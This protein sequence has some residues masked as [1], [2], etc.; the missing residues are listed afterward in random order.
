MSYDIHE[1]TEPVPGLEYAEYLAEKARI[2][3]EESGFRTPRKR[4]RH[5]APKR[6]RVRMLM[7][8]GER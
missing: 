4:R 7:I 3:N 2:G 1:K 6:L 8:G 5:T